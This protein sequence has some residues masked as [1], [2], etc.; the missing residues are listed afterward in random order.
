MDAADKEG[1]LYLRIQKHKDLPNWGGGL[2]ALSASNAFC[3]ENVFIHFLSIYN[4]MFETKRKGVPLWISRTLRDTE[5]F[6][7]PVLMGWPSLLLPPI[8]FQGQILW[9]CSIS[10]CLSIHGLLDERGRK[11]CLLS[12]C[13]CLG[14]YDNSKLIFPERWNSSRITAAGLPWWPSG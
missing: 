10:F 5:G 1:R 14:P 6:L 12:N 3:E 11:F 9:T 13:C 8:L 4:L 7:P 2:Y